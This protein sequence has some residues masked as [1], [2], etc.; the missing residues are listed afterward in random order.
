M[1]FDGLTLIVWVDG[2]D[3]RSVH[4][5][6][7]QLRTVRSS[8]VLAMQEQLRRLHFK[9]TGDAKLATA[10]QE[11]EVIIRKAAEMNA[12]P[13]WCDVGKQIKTAI[14]VKCIYLY[15]RA[16]E[17]VLDSGASRNWDLMDCTTV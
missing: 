3:L 13:A 1:G 9:F 16:V 5:A 15:A 10:M 6:L 4:L 11:T 14:S 8:D 17:T 2:S 7:L 12:V